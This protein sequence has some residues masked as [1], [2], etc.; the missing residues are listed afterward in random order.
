[1]LSG[2][3]A[4]LRLAG[5]VVQCVDRRAR[6]D[7]TWDFV[8][9]ARRR[10]RAG[11]R[12]A[13]IG[14][15]PAAFGAPNGTLQANKRTPEQSA[16]TVASIDAATPPYRASC[17]KCGAQRIDAQIG[18]EPLHDCLAWARSEPPCASCYV[19]TLREVFA[20]VWRVLRDDGVVFLNLGDWYAGS[21][22]TGGSGKETLTGSKVYQQVTMHAGKRPIGAGLKPKDL[23]GIPW[24]VA[25][26]LQSDGY[27]LRSD[28]IWSKPN[29]MPESVTDR[30]TRAH[31][32]IFVL[33]KRPT[34]FWD[35][36]AVR[37][38]LVPDSARA[39]KYSRRIDLK[40]AS[41]GVYHM[42]GDQPSAHE[43]LHDSINPAGRNLRSVWTIATQPYAGAHFATFPEALVERCILAGTSPQACEVLRRAVGTGG[44]AC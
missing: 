7:C 31:E 32:Y 13:I 38:Q 35:Q 11:T 27:F 23:I 4:H 40:G 6:R 15:T 18:L 26:A 44:G 41:S 33:T 14:P 3:C 36:E 19:C 17:G 8:T 34:Y 21:N 9:T 2:D 29:P 16:G 25:L 28:V 1:M 22:Q 39:S 30:P 42:N 12:G 37:E 20:G 24:R 10:G 5:E 43:L